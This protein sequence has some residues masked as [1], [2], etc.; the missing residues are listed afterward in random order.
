M[1]RSTETMLT[2]RCVDDIKYNDNTVRFHLHRCC[3][4]ELHGGVIPCP[5]AIY[6]I[7]AS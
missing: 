3:C 4:S 7:L 1:S 5:F 6:M 2:N